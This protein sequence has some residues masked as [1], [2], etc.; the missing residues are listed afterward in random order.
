M[1]ILDFLQKT[2]LS[3]LKVST[4]ISNT[5]WSLAMLTLGSARHTPQAFLALFLTTFGTMR[6]N[7]I[8]TYMQTYSESAGLGRAEVVVATANLL[9]YVK[10]LAPLLYS[11]LFNW[12]TTGGRSIPGLP[13]YVIALMTA[14][15]QGSFW[16]AAP[17]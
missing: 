5:F 3:A 10:V 12:A 16:L 4:L 13:Y 11:N 9:A 17:R 6:N 2:K 7:S 15:A 8:S 14:L 1:L